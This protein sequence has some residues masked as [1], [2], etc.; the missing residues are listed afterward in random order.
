MQNISGICKTKPF[1]TPPQPP[2]IIIYIRFFFSWATGH[3][4]KYKKSVT[5][6]RHKF[7]P[8]ENS[9]TSFDKVGESLESRLGSG[10][11]IMVHCCVSAVASVL[12][13]LLKGIKLID[14]LL[15]QLSVVET[16]KRAA[17]I[18]YIFIRLRDI[19]KGIIIITWHVFC[20]AGFSSL[21]PHSQ[22]NNN[23]NRPPIVSLCCVPCEVAAHAIQLQDGVWWV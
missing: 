21:P 13:A 15:I 9:P 11:Q 7:I 1:M 18:G 6:S 16:R 5:D 20:R 19:I 10:G 2:I 14:A 4:I 17:E 3:S 23:S 22:H 12:L 8:R